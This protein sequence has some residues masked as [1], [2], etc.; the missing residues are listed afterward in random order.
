MG[1]F[2]KG[3]FATG[4]GGIIDLATKALLSTGSGAASDK[5]GFFIAVSKLG[6]V[7]RIDY[8]VYLKTITSSG[9]T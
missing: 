2:I 3:D 7:M 5:S 4:I 1:N 9:L 6:A 8:T